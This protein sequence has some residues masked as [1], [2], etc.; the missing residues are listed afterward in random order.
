MRFQRSRID[1]LERKIK[2]PD[3]NNDPTSLIERANCLLH[4]IFDPLPDDFRPVYRPEDSYE[5][6]LQLFIDA[7]KDWQRSLGEDVT[8]L[9]D[10]VVKKTEYP[11]GETVKNRVDTANRIIEGIA[12]GRTRPKKRMIFR[13]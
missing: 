11:E 13:I 7:V 9:D 8:H 2:L 6:K 1:Q 4:G 12:E 3:H 5:T 10:W